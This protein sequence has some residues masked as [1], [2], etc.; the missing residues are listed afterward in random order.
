[1]E[2]FIFTA[3]HR[4]ICL[5]VYLFQIQY[6]WL[7]TCIRHCHRFNER[8]TIDFCFNWHKGSLQT[9]CTTLCSCLIH[10]VPFCSHPS[11][12]KVGETLFHQDG[13]QHVNIHHSQ[14]GFLELIHSGHRH[15]HTFILSSFNPSILH[16][17]HYI[18]WETSAGAAKQGRALLTHP[19]IFPYFWA[20]SQSPR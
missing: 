19:H 2:T 7:L 9:F 1:M 15:K 12:G 16:I 20:H 6:T 11:V 18:G 5:F 8:A 17:M 10:S 13:F 4:S 3:S 14:H